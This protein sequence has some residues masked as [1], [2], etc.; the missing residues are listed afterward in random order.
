MFSETSKSE[1]TLSQTEGVINLFEENSNYDELITDIHA[2]EGS[3]KSGS[4]SWISTVG[5]FSWT[6]NQVRD[7]DVESVIYV[8]DTFS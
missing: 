2:R 4:F 5:K 6:N 7:E 1:K 8:G 3:I